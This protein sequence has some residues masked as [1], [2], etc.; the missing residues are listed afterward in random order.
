MLKKTILLSGSIL[1]IYTFLSFPANPIERT[2]TSE[3]SV[4]GI[5]FFSTKQLDQ[6]HEFYINQVGCQLWLDQ[7]AC[8]IYKFGNM[9]FG[10]CKG[11][12]KNTAGTITFFFEKKEDV[13][14]MFQK[15]KKIAKSPPNENKKF[16]IYHFYAQDPE[17]RSIE[18][19]H[20][21]HPLD[22]DFD[23]YKTNN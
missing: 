7:G 20:F 9:L 2:K 6:I 5:I 11:N 14:R 18:F 10:F 12:K 16:R 17:G 3:N 15:F 22:W 21:L 4:S 8:Q 19:Q 23:L 13:D 1:F